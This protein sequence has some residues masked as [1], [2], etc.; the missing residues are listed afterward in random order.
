MPLMVESW[1]EPTTN[2]AYAKLSGAIE[3]HSELD[4]L[5]ESHLKSWGEK[6][7]KVWAIGDIRELGKVNYS[8]MAYFWKLA[9]KLVK[10]HSA[11]TVIIADSFQSVFTSRLY[12]F[13]TSHKIELVESVDEAL[14]IIHERQKV[15]GV[16]VPLDFG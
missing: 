4:N 6:G 13:V 3:S 16:L 9:R 15:Q 11:L 12:E 5:Y 14:K 10:D 1:Y 2:V 8:Q 7:I